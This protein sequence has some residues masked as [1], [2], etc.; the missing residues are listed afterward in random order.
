[1][2]FRMKFFE[3]VSTP[4][5]S[6]ERKHIDLT[7]FHKCTNGFASAT[8]N[9]VDDTRRKTS[10]EGF[11]QRSHQQHPIFSRFEYY[12]VTHDQSRYQCAECLVERV[13]KRSH[14]KCYTQRHASDLRHDALI[15]H[16]T[17]RAPIQAF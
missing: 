13:V 1:M 15:L 5:R 4:V 17:R 14:T 6:D 11:Q 3:I 10:A 7:S 8:I 16:K 2:R 12:G 9:D